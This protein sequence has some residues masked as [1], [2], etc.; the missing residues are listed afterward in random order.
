MSRRSCR[1]TIDT[2]SIP[3][4][5]STA[6]NQTR[7]LSLLDHDLF[8][9]PVSTFRDHALTRF[10]PP[11]N[12]AGDNPLLSYRIAVA[13]RASGYSRLCRSGPKGYAGWQ[14]TGFDPNICIPLQSVLFTNVRIDELG[15]WI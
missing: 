7:R 15:V 13:A 8:R 14:A 4:S 1:L 6:L 2:G 11:W 12:S 10:T 9:K 5:V 3:A